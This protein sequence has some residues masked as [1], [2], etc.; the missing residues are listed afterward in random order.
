M[1]TKTLSQFIART[2]YEDLPGEVI[3]AAKL[4]ILDFIGVAMAGSQEPS[5]KI[6]SEMV[7]ES[8]SPP[9]ATV[10]GGRFKA[11]SQLAALANGTS[12][13]TLDYDD[14]LD[15]PDIGLGH[16]STGTLP[17]ALAVSE[18]F[19]LT[20]K[21]LITAYTLGIEAYAKIGLLTRNRSS[22]RVGWEWTG[23][24]GVMGATAAVSK[25]IKLN[26]QQITMGFGI[27]G[28][29]SSGLIRNFGTMAGHLHSGNAAHNGV[30]AGILAGKGFVSCAGLIEIPTGFYSTYTGSPDD[31]SNEVLDKDLKALGNPWNIINPGLM[32]KAFPCA[33]IS[34]FGVDAALQMRKKY[35]IDWQK[36][37]EIE[38]HI[39]PFIQRA[40]SYSEPQTGVEG[41]FSLG[42]C[43]SRALIA[44]KINITDFTNENVKDED[45]R[46]LMK[47]IKWVVMEQQP[48]G[49]P[50]GFQ[51][52]I[53]KMKDGNIHS[54]KVEHPR[55][56]P[57]NP[58]TEDEFAAK[59]LNCA[60][61]AGYDEKNASR[62]KDLILGLE[63]V[64]D[65]NQ[66]TDL[67]GK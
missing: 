61:H 15:F 11:S 9:E 6:V 23:V 22:S 13:H 24:L 66:L 5:G 20:G 49:G 44:G 1:F 50:F 55:G 33:H 54:C 45:T 67:M 37:E 59:Y 60:L 17:A 26:E 40:V 8:Q 48:A 53:L 36:I 46:R 62:I 64:E 43:L 2:S 31:L 29:L 51:E 10:I 35:S 65:V 32:F 42:Y 7:R 28:S 16:P 3:T 58:L 57:Q 21:D 4:A 41:K 18:K 14:C 34:H 56:E 39:P 47:K 12:G 38:F 19:H 63:K 52:V 30:Q 27:A 25:L